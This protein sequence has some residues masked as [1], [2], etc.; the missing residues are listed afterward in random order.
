MARRQGHLLVLARR[1]RGGL[2]RGLELYR[3]L[4]PMGR[5]YRAV[6]ASLSKSPAWSLLPSRVFAAS[7]E[8]LV[9][10][11]EAAGRVDA[12]LFGN[13][14]QEHRRVILLMTTAGGRRRVIKAGFT[15]AA[16]AA[17][18]R[19]AVVLEQH[20]GRIEGLPR[21]VEVLR[22]DG[23]TALV[24]EET[25]GVP[26]GSLEEGLEG[27]IELL[28]GWFQGGES[29][30]LGSF[31]V[32]PQL[33]GSW[34]GA[35]SFEELSLQPAFAH[36]DFALWNLLKA[37]DG[38]VAAVDWEWAAVEQLPGLDLVHLVL[39]EQAMRQRKS[40]D[41]LVDGTLEVL[42]RPIVASFLERCGWPRPELPLACYAC[43][44]NPIFTGPKGPDL[45]R[46]CRLAEA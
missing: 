23:E 41:A 25:P 10:R 17:V 4:R 27:A 45:E 19:E 37:A 31:D 29:R 6:L 33:L 36:G 16:I 40:G 44:L 3:A 26:V 43:L 42:R 9:S 39:Q 20:G 21:P 30:P 14:V 1:E 34:P 8:G 7:P 38:R 12:I 11:L 18:E 13:P 46:L 24:M 5:A 28:G 32:F 2:A 15:P 35:A 22:R